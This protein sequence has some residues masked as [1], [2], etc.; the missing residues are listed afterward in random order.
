MGL[1][2]FEVRFDF[3]EYLI[4]SEFTQLLEHLNFSIEFIGYLFEFSRPF[5]VIV[6]SQVLHIDPYL[7]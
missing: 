5:G 2:V 1:V 3:Y 4:N 6:D 7:F